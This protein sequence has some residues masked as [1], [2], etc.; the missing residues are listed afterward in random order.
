[1]KTL[2]RIIL[3]IIIVVVLHKLVLDAIAAFSS[4][5]AGLYWWMSPA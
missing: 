1:M 5:I 3:I 2:L 4:F